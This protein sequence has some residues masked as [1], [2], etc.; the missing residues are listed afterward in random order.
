MLVK[1]FDSSVLRHPGQRLL[2]SAA[3]YNVLNAPFLL[4][5]GGNHPR[6]SQVA[7]EPVVSSGT[8]MVLRSAPIAEDFRIQ[9]RG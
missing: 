1:V 2:S 4:L 6:M 7:A 5:L 8:V 9:R 3:R